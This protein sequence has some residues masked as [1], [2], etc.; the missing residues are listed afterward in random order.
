[1]CSFTSFDKGEIS[2]LST[3]G[4]QIE[5]IKTPRSHRVGRKERIR[6]RYTGHAYVHVIL[7]PNDVT[8]SGLARV[9]DD[10]VRSLLGVDPDLVVILC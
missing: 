1:M 6:S 7:D 10:S 2:I 8:F 5:G 4:V 3:S 9:F